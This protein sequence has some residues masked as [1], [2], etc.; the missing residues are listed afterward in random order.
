MTEYQVELLTKHKYDK[1]QEG[2]EDDPN[3]IEYSKWTRWGDLTVIST[4]EIHDDKNPD[5]MFYRGLVTMFTDEGKRLLE[6]DSERKY[7][8]MDAIIGSKRIEDLVASL[9]KHLT[10][11]SK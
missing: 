5:N 9:T 1:K 6:W 2:S 3:L 10:G 11:D 8:M 7:K 4:I